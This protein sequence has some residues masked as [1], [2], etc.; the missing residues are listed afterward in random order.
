MDDIGRTIK[1]ELTNILAG[2]RLL[3]EQDKYNIK[4]ED[5]IDVLLDI[6]REFTKAL[7]LLKSSIT[8]ES[9]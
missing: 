1:N 9:R 4:S 8:Q 7:T 5:S 6:T 2:T 3:L